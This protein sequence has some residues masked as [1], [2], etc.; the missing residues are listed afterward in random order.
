M[1]RIVTGIVLIVAGP[2]AAAPILVDGRGDGYDGAGADVD[3]VGEGFQFGLGLAG[4]INPVGVFCDRGATCHIQLDGGGIAAN[5]S[6]DGDMIG[7]YLGQTITLDTP[8]HAEA[9]F[10]GFAT[11]NEQNPDVPARVDWSGR[12]WFDGIELYFTGAGLARPAFNSYPMN[13]PGCHNR[14]CPGTFFVFRSLVGTFQGTLT[15]YR[16]RPPRCSWGPA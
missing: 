4:G 5:L 9:G 16:S 12:I 15:K 11:F 13:D 14:P 3:L 1:F 8:A 10:H 7:V 6:E 2:L